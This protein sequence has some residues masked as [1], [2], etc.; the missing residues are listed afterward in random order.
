[1]TVGQIAIVA[2]LALCVASGTRAQSDR[3]PEGRIFAL[4]SA[5]TGA[6]PSL[7]WHIVVELHD[8]LAG[9][10]A[11]DNMASMARASGKINRSDDSFT[12]IAVQMGGHSRKLRID[13]HIDQR[14]WII[15]NLRGLNATCTAIEVPPSGVRSDAE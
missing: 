4:H 3:V 12:M 15:A 13:G 10:I 1:M 5:A 14:G 8:V 2:G 7:D 11:W 6:C 9:M